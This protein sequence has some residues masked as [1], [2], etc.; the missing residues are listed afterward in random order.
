MDC[1]PRPLPAL[2][3]WCLAASA[4]ALL[5]P[6]ASAQVPSTDIFV[7]EVASAPG[8]PWRFAAP[9]NLTDRAGYDNQPAFLA[10][11]SALLYTSMRGEQTDIY[12]HD[13]AAGRAEQLTE[14]PESEYSP[15]PIDGDRAFSVVRVE[16]DERQRLWRFAID[17]SAPELLLPDIA[18]VGYH[19]WTGDQTLILFVLGE[20]PTL[21]RAT[22]GPG[23]GERLASSIGRGF[24]RIPDDGRMSF[25]H[26][27]SEH[28]WWVV[29]I[30]PA[31]AERS[32]LVKLR[33]DREDFAWAKDGSLFLGDGSRLFRYSP[34]APE[35]GWREIV[36]LAPHGIRDITRLTWSADG[37]RLALVAAHPDP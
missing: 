31:T 4:L 32:A 12:R 23:P 21:E 14:T 24:G 22:V 18:P 28:D 3:S 13:L 36:D 7:L 34:D 26:K 20:P 16:A 11:G 6:P 9:R 8:Q 2:R 1:P 15:T 33:P 19:A 10:S 25:V 27:R 30:D 35:A 29:A 5:A 17:G 37:R